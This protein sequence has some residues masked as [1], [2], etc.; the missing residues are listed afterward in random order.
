M[1][2]DLQVK[3]DLNTDSWGFT[4]VQQCPLTGDRGRWR[5]SGL[6]A[7]VDLHSDIGSYRYDH[8]KGWV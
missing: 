4:A 8:E 5:G 1:R 2:S 3:P 7:D 6:S